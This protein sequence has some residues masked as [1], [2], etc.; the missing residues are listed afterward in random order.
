MV[1]CKWQLAESLSSDGQPEKKHF[2]K[3]P[4]MESSLS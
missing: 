4:M 1:L 3:K 2:S